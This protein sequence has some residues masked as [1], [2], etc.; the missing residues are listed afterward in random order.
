[1]PREDGSSEGLKRCDTKSLLVDFL[2]RYGYPLDYQMNVIVENG[3]AT[4]TPDDA[5]AVTENT[6]G[7]VKFHWTSMVSGTVFGWPDRPVGNFKGKAW[8][9]SFFNLLHNACGNIAGQIGPHYD[10]RPRSIPARENELKALVKAQETLPVHLRETMQYRMPFPHIRDAKAGLDHVFHFLNHREHHACEGFDSILKLRLSEHDTYRPI[11]ELIAAGHSPDALRALNPRPILETPAERY[12]RLRQGFRF[13]RLPLAV[14]PLL[15]AHHR[16]VVV[17]A[18]GEINLGSKSTPAVYRDLR[19]PHLTVGRKF[20][21]Y[22]STTDD[23]WVHLTDG[24][25][26][27]C[28]VP[29]TDSVSMADREALRLAAADK[30]GQIKRVLKSVQRLDIEAPSRAADLEHNLALASQQYQDSTVLIPGASDATAP[31]QSALV[32]AEAVLVEGKAH[33]A[34][35][36]DRIRQTRGNLDDIFG[37]SRPAEVGNETQEAAVEQLDKLF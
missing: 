24:R 12:T 8:L 32:G 15:L 25:R 30:Y 4:I 37:G 7:Q 11:S 14:A 19:S 13:A 35:A 6:Q 10:G 36:E 21:A 27:I 28:S 2:L 26:Y 17:E 9:E 20:L 22:A 33:R 23:A 31:A 16:E 29:R 3:T 5:K 34:D 1:L 18:E